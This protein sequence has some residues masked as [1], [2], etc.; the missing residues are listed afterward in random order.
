MQSRF[1]LNVVVSKRA[2]V[3]QLLAGKD[4]ALLVWGNAFLVLDLLLDVL[5]GVGRVDIQGDG[6]ARQ[7]LDKDLHSMVADGG[8]VVFGFR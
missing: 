3:F 6:L 4:Q 2:A 5:D 7:G 8:K 1:L